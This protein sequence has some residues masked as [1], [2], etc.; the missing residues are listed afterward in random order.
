MNSRI[1]SAGVNANKIFRATQLTQIPIYKRIQ[2]RKMKSQVGC[3]AA[4]L[5]LILI[6]IIYIYRNGGS[7]NLHFRIEFDLSS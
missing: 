4:A 7:E 6:G 5:S 2:K 1:I 3:E